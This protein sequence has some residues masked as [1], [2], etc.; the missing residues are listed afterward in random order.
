MIVQD[1]QLIQET[2][3]SLPI[4]ILDTGNN[5]MD[6]SGYDIESYIK[7]SYGDTGFAASLNP[8]TVVPESGMITLNLS[9]ND[10]T[11]IPIGISFYDVKINNGA[12]TQLVLA[13][14]VY[15]YPSIT[16]I[17]TPEPLPS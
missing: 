17:Q 2:D 14:K 8:Q 9:A 12:S 16:V 1:L 7:N 10:T 4:T 5:P 15:T 13:G 11:G 6:L 3:F